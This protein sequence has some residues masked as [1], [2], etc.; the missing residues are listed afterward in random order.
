MSKFLIYSSIH[1]YGKDLAEEIFHIIFFANARVTFSRPWDYMRR[2]L[3]I[4][5]TGVGKERIAKL[6]GETLLSMNPKQEKE[7]NLKKKEDFISINAASLP[8][9]LLESELF[10][11]EKGAYTGLDH[12]KDGLLKELD[13]GGCLFLDEVT[14]TTPFFQAKLLRVAQEGDYKPLG[15]KK[16]EESK[17]HLITA[18]N[19][20]EAEVKTNKD[21]RLDLFYRIASPPLTIPSLEE[22]FSDEANFQSIWQCLVGQSLEEIGI[23][24]SDY[25]VKNDIEGELK[26]KC[27]QYILENMRG[28]DWPG[29]LREFVSLIKELL[30]HGIDKGPDICKKYS[31][32]REF[33]ESEKIKYES[34]VSLPVNLKQKIRQIEKEYYQK[35]VEDSK[36]IEEVARKLDITRQTAARRLEKFHFKHLLKE[37]DIKI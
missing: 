36:N 15:S 32:I 19:K 8:E 33:K 22:L 31:N 10:G 20:S 30:S 23:K 28:Y 24:E 7:L 17:F 3:I 4:G 9:Q 5:D 1:F 13:G 16:T 2:I 11:A 35:A 34:D 25:Q 18:T 6:I 37:K 12:K 14:E 26:K 21:F 29:N 27:R